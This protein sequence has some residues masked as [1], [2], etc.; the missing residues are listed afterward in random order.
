METAFFLLHK[1][2]CKVFLILRLCSITGVF[3]TEFDQLKTLIMSK[4][5]VPE[6]LENSTATPLPLSKID[7]TNWLKYA[8]YYR[9]TFYTN[10]L[11]SDLDFVNCKY[12]LFCTIIVVY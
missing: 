1:L 8:N 9:R 5:K 11:L 7:K 3:G 10:Y 4:N 6:Y 12:H 2:N